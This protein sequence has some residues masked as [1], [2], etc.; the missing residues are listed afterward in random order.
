[1]PAYA[2]RK[3][4]KYVKINHLNIKNKYVDQGWATL[5]APLDT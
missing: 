3:M 5:L 1:M 2:I 4:E